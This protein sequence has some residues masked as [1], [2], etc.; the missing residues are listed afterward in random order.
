MP[1]ANL[2]GTLTWEVWAVQ[3]ILKTETACTYTI[4]HAPAFGVFAFTQVSSFLGVY[5]RIILNCIFGQQSV[6]W[7]HS[8]QYRN[9][10]QL[11]KDTATH[12]PTV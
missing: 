11:P 7:F 3:K 1:N 6:D 2:L 12:H 9:Q 8:T 4:R 5:G 10:W